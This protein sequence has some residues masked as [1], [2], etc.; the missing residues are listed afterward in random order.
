MWPQRSLSEQ[1]PFSANVQLPST[2]FIV[3]IL[4]W[5]KIRRATSH[6]LESS[7]SQRRYAWG[8]LYSRTS[9]HGWLGRVHDQ[10]MR[11]RVLL[12]ATADQTDLS[13]C[14]HRPVSLVTT[15]R[16]IRMCRTLLLRYSNPLE[17]YRGWQIW[18]G[19]SS[20]KL[21]LITESAAHVSSMLAEWRASSPTCPVAISG[22]CTTAD[23]SGEDSQEV[24]RK[25]YNRPLSLTG[26]VGLSRA[27]YY[28]FPGGRGEDT[29]TMVFRY[30]T[31]VPG[32]EQLSFRVFSTNRRAL[33]RRAPPQLYSQPRRTPLRT[34]D[35]RMYAELRLSR[36]V[37]PSW[38][39]RPEYENW[40]GANV[41]GW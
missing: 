14:I 17:G 29:D 18:M 8:G 31:S 9:R 37:S 3:R 28:F 19:I 1:P 21:Q 35:A 4:L 10:Q 24:H 27:T 30:L 23:V 34:A 2:H 26:V 20:Q 33:A 32:T 40:P 41:P 11:E 12:R 5:A 22:H 7:S 13:P 36:G 39:T 25:G 15:R 6:R 38:G 16:A